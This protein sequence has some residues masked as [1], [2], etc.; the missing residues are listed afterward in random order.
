M[1]LYRATVAAIRERSFTR[2]PF[3]KSTPMEQRM[4]FGKVR[5]GELAPLTVLP[6]AKYM[7]E[8]V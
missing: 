2:Y 4:L 1:V 6:T 3:F 8:L 7:H 5:T